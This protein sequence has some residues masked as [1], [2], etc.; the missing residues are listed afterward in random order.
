MRRNER[1]VREAGIGLLACKL[2]NQAAVLKYFAKYRVSS[3][4]EAADLLRMA[5]RRIADVCG[6]LLTIDVARAGIRSVAMGYEG[7]AAAIYWSALREMCAQ[8]AVFGFREKQNASNPIQQSLNLCYSFLYAECWHAIRQH[9]LDPHF[10]VIHGAAK[11]DGGALV[12]DL[13]EP[14]RAPFADRTVLALVGRGMNFETGE[15]GRLSRKTREN[16]HRAIS[17]RLAKSISWRGDTVTPRQ[18]IHR[19]AAMFVAL[20]EERKPLRPY[21]MKW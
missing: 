18:L 2:S 9:R 15:D 8:K 21:R 6:Q 5:A 12:F 7:R 1:D 4:P 16:V 10:G 11:A 17:K 20:L 14:F 13:M 3:D 19:H